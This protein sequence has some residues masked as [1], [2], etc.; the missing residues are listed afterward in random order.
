MRILLITP[1][2]Y[3]H[4][5]GSQQYAEELY[6]HLMK[7]DSSVNVDVLC[8]STDSVKSIEKYRGFT[9]Y[10]IPCLELLPG[11]FAL[12]NYGAL[13]KL[14]FRLR[15]KHKYTWVNAHTRFFESTWW[16]P[17]AAKLLGAQS[18][19]TDH[20]AYHP[21]HTSF[22]VTKIATVLDKI[23]SPF[24]ARFYTQVTVT[25]KTTQKFLQTLGIHNTRL[26][27]GGVDTKVFTPKNQKT[28]KI[29]QIKKSFSQ[30]EIIV[31]FIGRMI[32]SK[33]PL[34]LLEAATKLIKR[35]PQLTVVFA[36][37]GPL[38]KKLQGFSSERILFLGSLGKK[39]VASLLSQTDIFVHPSRHHEGFP[40]AVL[41][42][43]SAE[44]TVIATK[45]GTMEIIQHDKTGLF[46]EPTVKSLYRAI[47]RALTDV[48]L[49]RKLGEAL[50][51]ELCEKFD[52]RIIAK[53]YKT[54]L[55]V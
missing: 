42:A 21:A 39:D 17:L 51:K 35:Y 15:K 23:L 55:Q 36:G 30:D 29:L 48:S 16:T 44:C 6:F 33:G 37:N 1:Y 54:I 52:W 28:R 34:L 47:E 8:Y 5:G 9:I 26:V 53:G 4:I 12:P 49:R 41:E 22:V 10:R 24:F 45:K 25:N 3:P 27:Y 43:G 18:L 40:N 32:A 13:I 38:Y 31:S 46:V 7:Q 2:F 14:L 50:R 20:C 19:L 11:Q